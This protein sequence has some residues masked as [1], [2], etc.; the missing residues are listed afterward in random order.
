MQVLHYI[1]TRSYKSM[2]VCI[3]VYA[4]CTCRYDIYIYIYTN[5]YDLTWVY[6]RESFVFIISWFVCMSNT[7]YVPL[8]FWRT[9]N[10]QGIFQETSPRC[11]PLLAHRFL[12][13][14]TGGQGGVGQGAEI[15]FDEWVNQQTGTK[16][17]DDILRKLMT[18]F[19][20]QTVYC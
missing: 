5:T 19:F 11:R 2:C 9:E 16:M 15:M 12:E 1:H 8:V 14:F 10:D 18:H 20:P 3:Y 4:N 6:A 13:D 17:R 7:L